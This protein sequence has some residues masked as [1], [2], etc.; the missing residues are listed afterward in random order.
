MANDLIKNRKKER[1]KL[2]GFRMGCW[3]WNAIWFEWWMYIHAYA[4]L[5]T[6]KPR[7]FFL[8][9]L[10][11]DLII[12]CRLEKNSKIIR[13]SILKYSLAF[14]QNLLRVCNASLTSCQAR[15]RPFFQRKITRAFIWNRKPLS[16]QN[17]KEFI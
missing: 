12:P 8:L 4:K 10:V 1:E 11:Y 14:F 9:C 6:N 13:Y 15:W 17:Q 16:K 2:L 3:N 7:P 5:E